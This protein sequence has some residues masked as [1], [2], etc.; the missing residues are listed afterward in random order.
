M[1]RLSGGIYVCQSGSGFTRCTDLTILTPG[2]ADLHDAL[3]HQF[4]KLMG[5]GIYTKKEQRQIAFRF[6]EGAYEDHLRSEHT[7]N[8][9]KG[10]LVHEHDQLILL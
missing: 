2:T 10:T 1:Y 7:Y 6:Q 3:T 9:T 5:T 4:H 8:K